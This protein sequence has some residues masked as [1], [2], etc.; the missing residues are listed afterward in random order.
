MGVPPEHGGP[1]ETHAPP[2]QTSS[3]SQKMPSDGQ[4]PA[5]RQLSQRSVLSLQYGVPPL[6]GPPAD[7]Q[8]PL[9]QSSAPVQNKPS[10]AQSALVKHCTHRSW[11]SLHRPPPHG[12]AWLV[13]PPP[14]HASAPLQ[15]WASVHWLS[16]RQ[17]TH[18]FVCSLQYGVAPAAHGVAPAAQSPEPTLQVSVPLQNSPSLQSA[19]WV[20]PPQMSLPSSQRSAEHGGVP[21]LQLPSMQ[22]STPSQ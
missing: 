22:C 14:E 6:Q 16:R 18:W 10:D 5:L 19:S 17:A 7:S 3:P 12:A 9:L 13:Q 8:V 1:L 11:P 2:L 20:Q 4:S 21:A 15:N